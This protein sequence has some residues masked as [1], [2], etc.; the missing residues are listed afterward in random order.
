MSQR[1]FRNPDY[2]HLNLPFPVA[3]NKR[4]VQHMI[5]DKRRK[6]IKHPSK[7]NVKKNRF[8]RTAVSCALKDKLSFYRN[9][10]NAFGNTLNYMFFKIGMGIYV[11]IH[12][13][14]VK[15][16]VPFA[17]M[18]YV[19]DWAEYITFEE[20]VDDIKFFNKKYKIRDKVFNNPIQWNTNNCLIGNRREDKGFPIS[21][22]RLVEIYDLLV[23]TCKKHKVK[24][25]E[26]FVNKRDFPVL[27]RDLTEPYHHIFNS[28]AVPLKVYKYDAYLPIFSMSG[29]VDFVDVLFPTDDD[30]AMYFR[31]KQFAK[32]MRNVQW[33]DKEQICLFRGSATGSGTTPQN[34]QRLRLA[35]MEIPCLDAKITSWNK[36]PKK[37]CGQP[38]SIINPSELTFKLGDKMSID[39]QCGYRYLVHVDGHVSAFRLSW[40][41]HSRS[42]ILMVE[43]PEKYELWFQSLL[44]PWRHYIPIRADMS[45]LAEKIEWCINND[46]ESKKIA[47]RAYRVFEKLVR[48]PLDYVAYCLNLLPNPETHV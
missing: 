8:Y 48:F 36:R 21:D 26:F 39:Q 13:N 1:L 31:R 12:D 35:E 11:N 46:A 20:G 28:R 45:D 30:I 14:L 18:E 41:L 29:S 3:A 44:R 47:N 17:N 7:Q 27:K 5:V 24:D 23:E 32:E 16:Y 42:L 34:N 4:Q 2:P 15:M 19:N 40:M 10:E 25:V 38:L 43:S 6:L 33:E 37:F 22:N 9:Q